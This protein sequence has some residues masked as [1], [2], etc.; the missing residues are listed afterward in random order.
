MLS[1]TQVAEESKQTISNA[2]V[3]AVNPQ[4]FMLTTTAS[5]QVDASQAEM[6]ITTYKKGEI[7]C[8]GCGLKH[9]LSQRQ[10]NGTYVMMCS[11]KAKPG[12]EQL[13]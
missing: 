6:T 10:D 2:A 12:V 8:F 11:N 4:G 13:L 9:P 3:T 1:A 7:I 5:A